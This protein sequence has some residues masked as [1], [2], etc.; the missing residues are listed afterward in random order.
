MTQVET[1]AKVRAFLEWYPMVFVDLH[2]MGSN[3]TY[4]FPPA[5]P[6]TRQEVTGPQRAWLKQFGRNNGK[7]F[8][9]MGYDYFTREVFD[10][11]YPGYGTSW[12]V[13]QGAL[14]MTYE[15]ASARGLVV[16]RSDDTVM[17]FWDTVQHHF[18]ASLSTIETATENRQELVRY[19][20]DFRKE[21][22]EKGAAETIKEYIFEPG[23]DPGR[24]ARLAEILVAQGIEVRRAREAF[25]NPEVDDYFGGEV[26]AREFGKGSFIVPLNQP[27]H[28]LVKALLAKNTPME[29]EFI[30]KQLKRRMKRQNSQ[31]YDITAWS[32]PLLFDVGAYRARTFSN[33]DFE[34]VETDAGVAG[35]LHE[36]EGAVAYLIPWGSQ[37]A[38]RALVRLH[39]EGVRVFSAGRDF[40]LGESS[41]PAGSLVVKVKNNPPDLAE[42]L[43]GLAS[44]TGVQVYATQTTWVE[45]GVSLGSG[46]VQLVKPPRVAMAYRSPTRP[47]SAGWARFVLEQAYGCPVTL[48]DT[49]QLQRMD[50]SKYNVLILPDASRR[51]GGGY[52]GSLGEGTTTRIKE[53]VT[54]GGTLVGIGGALEW[55]TAEKVGL[56]DSKREVLKRKKGEGDSVTAAVP[57]GKGETQ[58]Q[59]DSGLLPEEELPP[60]NPG[61]I[62]RVDLDLEHWLAFGYQGPVNVL[63]SSRNVYVPIRLD[64]GANVGRFASGDRLLVSGFIWEELEKLMAGKAFIMSQRH[65]RGEVV[66][67]T[68]DPNYRAFSDGLNILFMNAVLFGPSR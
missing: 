58:T 3:S 35:K 1:Q 68:E 39:R 4:Y 22:V 20:Y 38:V 61:S 17:T 54:A 52:A 5:A 6:P 48:L 10:D 50:L 66:G 15:Q 55:L 67:F 11:F 36:L 2:E 41:F 8:D 31:I 65:G 59:P 42:K 33:G 28:N 14:G 44:E 46:H 64:K 23:N 18:I 27:A 24:A 7:W 30:E 34:M 45:E 16:E 57:G 25:S 53:W 37:A 21:A 26:K 60:S 32:L 47:Y 62:L 12:P 13:T 51:G 40:T 9:R 63:G 43:S 19:Y 56:L 29:E 49:S